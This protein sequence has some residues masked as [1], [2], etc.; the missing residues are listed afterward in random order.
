MARRLAQDLIDYFNDSS[1]R[2]AFEIPYAQLKREAIWVNTTMSMGGEA[3]EVEFSLSPVWGKELR[4]RGFV[5]FGRAGQ[6]VIV[7][8]LE[9][10]QEETDLD[11]VRREATLFGEPLSPWKKQKPKRRKQ[12]VKPQ[13][14][15]DNERLL[16]F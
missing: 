16:I 11:R 10:I 4:G 7:N 15:E 14:K 6:V 1:Q 2:R 8:N 9:T 13:Q 5:E 3:T 12:Q